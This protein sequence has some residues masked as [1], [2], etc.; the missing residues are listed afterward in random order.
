LTSRE[1]TVVEK[2]LLT[3]EEVAEA[4]GL[5]R[6]KVYALIRSRQLRSVKL[7]GSRRIAAAALREFVEEL[8]GG[9]AA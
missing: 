3:V 2:L 4:L 8:D 7:D 5:S 1:E 6:W 9:N